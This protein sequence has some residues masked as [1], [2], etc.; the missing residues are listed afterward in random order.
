MIGGNV[1]DFLDHVTY[2]EAAVRYKGE[3]YFFYGLLKNPDTG[4]FEFTIDLW[5]DRGWY[6]KTVY[7]A[8]AQTDSECMERFLTDPIID[9]ME[10]GYTRTS[11]PRPRNS[12]RTSE[13]RNLELLPVT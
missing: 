6:V 7:Q 8:V 5:D 2:E 4:M 13:D 10:S 12:V 1:N 11:S 3:K 9:G